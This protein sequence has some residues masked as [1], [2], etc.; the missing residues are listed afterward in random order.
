LNGAPDHPEASG[1]DVKPTS[2]GAKET[3]SSDV[4]HWA[5]ENALAADS[6]KTSPLEKIRRRPFAALQRFTGT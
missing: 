2:D 5:S 1:S 6:T 4:K 3:P